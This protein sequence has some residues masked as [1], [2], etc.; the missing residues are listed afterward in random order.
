MTMTCDVP[1]F[2]VQSAGTGPWLTKK[3]DTLARRGSAIWEMSVSPAHIPPILSLHGG[4]DDRVPV[5]QAV[6]FRRGC[7]HYRIPCELVVY[8]R[9]GHIFVERAH[10]IDMARRVQRFCDAHLG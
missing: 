3:E 5:S 10:L 9:E 6:A 7:L 8:P 2:G 4:S 1:T